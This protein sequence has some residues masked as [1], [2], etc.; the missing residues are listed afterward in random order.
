MERWLIAVQTNC[1]DPSREKEFNDWYNNVHVP[2][3]LKV[4]GLLNS[5]RFYCPDWSSHEQ[6][7]YLA[8]YEIET[9]DIEK[10]KELLH[11]NL[12][13]WFK[14][15][16]MSDSITVVNLSFYKPIFSLSR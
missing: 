9:D 13:E 10:T 7:H 14:K 2:D 4:P 11:T 12:L 1:T 6:G 8:L 5:K 15:G 16:R 3:I